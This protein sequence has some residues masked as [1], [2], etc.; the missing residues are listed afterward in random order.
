VATVRER[1][2][3]VWE[4][5]VFTGRDASGRPTQISKTV[6]G[7]KREAQRVAAT[8]E[9]R[10]PSNAAGRTVTDVLTAWRDVN[11]PVW[12]E[13]TRRDYESRIA[14]IEADQIAEMPVARLRV[15]D[16][17]RWHARMRKTGVGEA[18]IRGRHSV[19][20]AALTQALRWELVGSNPASQAI[21]RQPKR[22][23][24][25]AMTPAD[26]RAVITSARELDPAA[27]VALRLAAVGGLRRAE[28]AALQW[29]DVDGN[30]LAIDS[31]ACVFRNGGESHVE[32]VATKTGN[33][34]TLTLDAA[35]VEEIAA[36]R[37]TREQASPYLFSDTDGPANPD[38]IGW[39]WNR[40]REQSGIDKKWRLHDLR[41]WTATTAITSGHD[42]RTVAGRLGHANPAMT[43]RVYAHAVEGADRAL[44]SS[45]AATLDGEEIA[46]DQVPAVEHSKGMDV[47]ARLGADP[48]AVAGFCLR[49]GVRRLAVFGSA[50]RDDFT[51]ESDVD[52]LVDFQPG[53]KV[54]LFDMARMEM[55]LEEIVDGHRIDLRTAG[56][57]G[58]RFRDEVVAE[59]EAV[60]D[61][62][63]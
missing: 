51:P 48:T 37:T 56:D 31:S 10:P 5:R 47:L 35:T 36:L 33:T 52:L 1:K 26:V 13:S 24:R 18:A 16:V 4:I 46:V 50:L 28:L 20:R 63:A 8:L 27:G 53:Q 9:S 2:P 7:T 21:L 55:E 25:D 59:A 43:L 17:E 14:H 44:A 54:S 39:W 38:R 30:Q 62:A 32:D 15:A 58:V 29:S 42:V 61:V 57:L 22:A 60:Y 3:G 45:I 34:R 41:H 6:R 40:A 12:A 11:Q 19:L 23:P 49:N